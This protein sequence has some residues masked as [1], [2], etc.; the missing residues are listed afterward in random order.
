MDWLLAA[1]GSTTTFA[2]V[3]VLDK[4]IL[5]QWAPSPR[6]FIVLT[7]LLQ[8]PAVLIALLIVPLEYHAPH[9][10][11]TAV[12]SGL[13]TGASLVVMFWV[14]SKGEVSR[15]TSVYLTS[16]IFVAMLAV[17]FLSET[18][19]PVHWSAICLTI[20]GAIL[21]S[22]Q[23]T[24]TAGRPVL[25]RSFLW[26]LLAALLSAGGQ[27]LSKMAVEDM[28]F[29]N[30]FVVRTL[31]LTVA[32][33]VLPFRPSVLA[34]TRGMLSSPGGAALLIV[35][36]AAIA[37][38]AV[39]LMLLA[40]SLG[41][42]SLVATVMSSRPLIVLTITVVL[43]SRMPGMLDE[44]LDRKTLVQKGISAAMIVGGICA[45]SIL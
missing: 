35:N 22:V 33:V 23:R 13:L 45:I 8:L 19:S 42:V 3:G 28:E 39:F 26:L 34:E 21:I 12:A 40:I 10:W 15:V 16:P 43:N 7:G 4:V 5:M 17:I 38:G 14:L 6:T 1:I 25:H 2:V 44:V 27:F 41:P 31:A 18:L 32:C 20:A 11:V 37:F 29:W 9:L 24:G 30:L 36:E